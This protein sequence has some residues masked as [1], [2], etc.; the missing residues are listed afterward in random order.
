MVRG[1]LLG[2]YPSQ[3]PVGF[4]RGWASFGFPPLALVLVLLVLAHPPD[5]LARPLQLW[6][7]LV[8]LLFA[9]VGPNVFMGVH[10]NRYLMWAFPGLLALTA[11]GLGVGT[12]LL[13]RDD[14]SLDRRLFTAGTALFLGLGLLST[15]RFANVFGQMA[16]EIYRRE[17]PA[18][19]WIRTNLPRGVAMANVATSV[20]Y[21]TGHRNLN[22]HG[23][24]TP[25]FFGT[26]TMEKEAG[27]YE[28]LTRIPPRIFPPT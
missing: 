14:E 17:I 26:L 1:L 12:R 24:T 6:A 8:A 7:V 5:A 11:V 27:L 10:F 18:A 9:L 2:L 20:E 22:L 3:A 15:L 4:A 23:V 21:L 16:G 19:E 25:A 13:A 28:A